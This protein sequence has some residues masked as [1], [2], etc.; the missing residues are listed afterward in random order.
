MMCKLTHDKLLLQGPAETVCMA[1]P[2]A[3]GAESA[4]HGG[5]PADQL[6]IGQLSTWRSHVTSAPLMAP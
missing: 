5:T 1:H 3:P 4:A 2:L 6:P